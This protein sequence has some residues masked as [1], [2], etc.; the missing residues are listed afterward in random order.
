MRTF[1]FLCFPQ[2]PF[3]QPVHSTLSYQQNFAHLCPV[4][5]CFEI[6]FLWQEN[7]SIRKR[8]FIVSLEHFER[9]P[10][11]SICYRIIFF[12]GK[13]LE[14]LLGHYVASPVN[15]LWRHLS[16]SPVVAWLNCL[17]CNAS[18]QLFRS[19]QSMPLSEV[20]QLQASKGE[21]HIAWPLMRRSCNHVCSL[22]VPS[23]MPDPGGSMATKTSCGL[24]AQSIKLMKCSTTMFAVA[25]PFRC[26][27]P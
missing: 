25:R 21:L 1:T 9:C 15:S 11:L 19:V 27:I 13:L 26:S 10:V 20:V 2:L 12:Y 16:P 14:Q 22:T 6:P 24:L 3:S 8:F 5:V 4:L 18:V 17:M 7:Q 23:Q